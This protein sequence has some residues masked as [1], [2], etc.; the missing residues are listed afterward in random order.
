MRMKSARHPYMEAEVR[1]RSPSRRL[2]QIGPDL[3]GTGEEHHDQ[4][5][6]TECFKKRTQGFHCWYHVRQHTIPEKLNYEE[7][8]GDQYED[9]KEA[10]Q[11]TIEIGR[12]R[13]TKSFLDGGHDGAV[14]GHLY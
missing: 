6:K 2:D 7:L 13:A 14:G 12:S 3:D 11:E 5:K 10:D 1:R 4:D 8:N 9:D